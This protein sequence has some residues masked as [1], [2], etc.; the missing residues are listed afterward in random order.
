MGANTQNPDFNAYQLNYNTPSVKGVEF[1]YYFL[2]KI[3]NFLGFS[4]STFRMILSIIG[5]LL[6][7]QTVSKLIKNKSPFYLLYFIYPFFMDVVQI[8]N[9]LAMALFIFSAPYLTS[10]KKTDLLKF[11]VIMFI[12]SSIHLISVF[13][14]PL[15]F[16]V[17]FFKNKKNILFKILF[18]EF[19]VFLIFISSNEYLF[20]HFSNFLFSVINSFD[21]RANF[22]FYKQTRLGFLYL[23]FL[24]L[25]NFTLSYYSY[26]LYK[27]RL[28]NLREA[29][30]LSTTRKKSEFEIS[31]F[32]L[33]FLEIV[34]LINLYAFSFLPFYVFQ[35]SFSRLMRNIVPLN[36]LTYIIS[37]KSF[38]KGS[39][40]KIFF[41]ILYVSYNLFLFYTDVY[42]LYSES[43]VK[44]IFLHNWLIN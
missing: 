11:L 41:I 5:I 25:M 4:Y 1:G 37:S 38:S 28:K 29:N 18:T 39:L 31:N 21:Y 6:I 26:S 42:S 8:R 33:K 15:A 16:F 14:F 13:Y 30:K 19:V 43:I 10:N 36:L 34:F 9:F 35:Y 44:A 20:N 24:Q 17:K 7:D 2:V 40:S 32:Q 3:F 23:W 12:A 22:Y 27:R